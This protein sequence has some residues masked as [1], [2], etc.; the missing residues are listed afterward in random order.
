MLLSAIYMGFSRCTGYDWA[1]NIKLNVVADIDSLPTL[2]AIARKG[3]ACTILLQS[4]FALFS[5][6]SWP[7]IR[8]LS[9]PGI[10][11]LASLCWPNALPKNA[12]TLANERFCT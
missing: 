1:A 11:R 10:Q 2:I 4:A 5:K 7:P 6:R 8:R 12:A 3:L 9:E